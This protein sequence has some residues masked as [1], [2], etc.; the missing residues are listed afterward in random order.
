MV[1]NGKNVWVIISLHAL[2]P[3]T[4]IK[5][6][7]RLNSE[8]IN[9]SNEHIDKLDYA[10]IKNNYIIN[11]INKFQKQETYWANLQ[12]ISKI[13]NRKA[14]MYHFTQFRLTKK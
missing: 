8:R 13:H 6:N 12:A 14:I 4:Y 1:S 3:V 11:T 9:N 2:F 5:V 10:I 7:V